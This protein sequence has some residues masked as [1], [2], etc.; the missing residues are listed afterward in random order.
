MIIPTPLAVNK[1]SDPVSS[2][3]LQLIAFSKKQL[4]AMLTTEKMKLANPVIDDDIVT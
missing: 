4:E 2:L 3:L 1:I